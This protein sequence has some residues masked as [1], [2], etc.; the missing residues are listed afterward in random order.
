MILSPV[1][2]PQHTP[3]LP[4]VTHTHARILTYEGVSQNKHVHLVPVEYSFLQMLSPRKGKGKDQV[5]KY[6]HCVII[7]HEVEI[8]TL[9]CC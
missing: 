4:T 2:G 9:L 3:P 6:Y 8:S 7:Y 5:V 1:L